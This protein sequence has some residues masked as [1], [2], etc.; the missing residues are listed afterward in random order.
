MD[1]LS[2][3]IL[4]CFIIALKGTE[5]T[6]ENTRKAAEIVTEGYLVS[7][8]EIKAIHERIDKLEKRQE[9]NV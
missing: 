8:E 6:T 3:L 2:Q 1:N 9:G 5:D 7:H 4:K